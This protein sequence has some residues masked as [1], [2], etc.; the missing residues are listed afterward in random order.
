[1]M[2]VSYLPQGVRENDDIRRSEAQLHGRGDRNP[3]IQR[4]GFRNR[5]T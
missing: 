4:V 3:R 2:L 5:R 1:M